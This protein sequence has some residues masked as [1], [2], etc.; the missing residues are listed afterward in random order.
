MEKISRKAGWEMVKIVLFSIFILV[1]FLA[2]YSFYRVKMH[3]AFSLG[4]HQAL[5][6]WIDTIFIFCMG[7][8]FQKVSGAV[9]GWYGRNVASKTI[10]EFDDKALPL[11]RQVSKIAIWVIVLVII[12]PLHGVNISALVATLGVGSLAIA[13]AAQDTISNIIAGFLIMVDA[14]FRKGDRIKIPSGEDVEVL[15]VGVRRSKFLSGDKKT[16]IIV[17][18]LDLSK[19]KIVNYTY[20]ERI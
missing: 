1:L 2:G 10:T 11:L 20:A 18:N 4:S 8:V 19:S 12:L 7:I 17:P 9:I 5:K 16:V 15:D 13:L 3:A 6:R 14:P